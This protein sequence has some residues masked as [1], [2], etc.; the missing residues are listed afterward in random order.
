MVWCARESADFKPGE[1]NAMQLFEPYGWIHWGGTTW[2]TVTGYEL[3]EPLKPVLKSQVPLSAA[4]A[5]ENPA[6]EHAK[7][8]LGQD[9]DPQAEVAATARPCS[10]LINSDACSP[11]MTQGAIV[12]PVVTRGRIEPS[13]I[14]RL[15]TP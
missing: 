2:H 14:R 15:S 10:A 5:L 12:L 13:A 7:E 11:I 6:F 4:F 1:S 3:G 8:A 9:A